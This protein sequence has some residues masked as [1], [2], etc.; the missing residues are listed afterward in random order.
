MD[1]IFEK[2]GMEERKEGGR[3]E[4][5]EVREKGKKDGK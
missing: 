5:K 3:E 2:E 1:N 4:R